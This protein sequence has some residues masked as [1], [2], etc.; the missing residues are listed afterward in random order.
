MDDCEVD[1]DPDVSMFVTFASFGSLGVLARRERGSLTES[2][3]SLESPTLTLTNKEY[4]ILH[5]QQKE[6][7]EYNCRDVSLILSYL[8]SLILSLEI[9]SP[10]FLFP[11]VS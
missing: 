10:M 7:K 5:T 11:V 1:G 6:G 9:F 2:P 3:T 8:R 4:R